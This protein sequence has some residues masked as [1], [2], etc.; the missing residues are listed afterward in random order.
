M[1][2]SHYKK[3]N[4]YLNIFIYRIILEFKKLAGDCPFGK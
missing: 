4:M 1:K 2:A 3:N